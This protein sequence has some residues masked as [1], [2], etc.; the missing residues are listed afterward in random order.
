MEYISFSPNLRN[1][2]GNGMPP[3]MPYAIWRPGYDTLSL[4]IR[5]NDP[6]HLQLDYKYCYPYGKSATFYCKDYFGNSYNFFISEWDK[7]MKN[8][9]ITKG[10][11]GGNFI[12]VKRG[13]RFSLSLV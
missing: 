1:S 12:F 3:G 6:Q 4:L 10:G 13:T 9:V 8:C 7:V 5:K 2:N 11:F